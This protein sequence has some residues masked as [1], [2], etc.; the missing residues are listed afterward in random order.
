MY[1]RRVNG[2]M[3]RK[4]SPMAAA[5]AI[6]RGEGSS[7]GSGDGAG[8]QVSGEELN[9]E[10]RGALLERSGEKRYCERVKKSCAPSTTPKRAKTEK[11][12]F[13]RFASLSGAEPLRNKAGR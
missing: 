6:L 1:W 7:H 11:K 2:Q 3:Q 8:V 12:F 9:Q 13:G 5:A 10:N 4:P